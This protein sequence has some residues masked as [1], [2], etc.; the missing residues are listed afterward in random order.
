MTNHVAWTEIANFHNVRK[1]LKTYPELLN[2]DPVV[3][4]WAKVK[5]HGTNAGVKVT[6]DGQVFA[7]SRSAVITPESDNAGFARFVHENQT[8]FAKLA[9]PSGDVIV[10]GEWCGKG[11]QKG[12]AVSE[13]AER[14]YAV[15]AVR[16][17][18]QGGNELVVD[19]EE[20]LDLMRF[21]C[22]RR[23]YVIPWYA[24]EAQPVEFLIDWS[25]DAETLQSTVDEINLHV[26]A[27]EV[28]DPWVKA[29][30]GLEGTGE[31]L[32]LYPRTKAHQGYKAFGDVGFK[33]KGEKHQIVAHTK[34]VQVDATAA[35][36]AAAF[37]ELVATEGRCD[38]G[39]RLVNGGEL[40]FDMKNMGAFLKWMNTD[41]LK[42]CQAEL[43][44]SGLDEKAAMRAASDR[45][46]NWY[47][48]GSRKL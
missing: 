33:A 43:E 14:V 17:M 21:M 6:P 8:E 35:A 9:R 12:V 42:E 37:A 38:Q 7:L 16:M 48:A 24:P 22:M 4:Y 3:L 10:Y 25:A 45:A 19:R 27:V 1:T 32:V 39:C 15:F 26:L 30:F 31:G 41:I 18:R 11:I 44:A 13:I 46:R 20:I 5:L 34:P 29:E 40:G 36:T 28:C 23:V 2:G 47:I